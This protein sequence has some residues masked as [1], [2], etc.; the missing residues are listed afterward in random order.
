MPK[1]TQETHTCSTKF[2]LSSSGRAVINYSLLSKVGTGWF[3][4]NFFTKHVS[5]KTHVCCDTFFVKKFQ[6][7]VTFGTREYTR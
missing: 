5:Y 4:W 1:E 6:P 2:D 3:I 7:V